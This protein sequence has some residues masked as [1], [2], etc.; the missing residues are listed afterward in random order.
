MDKTKV[1]VGS[2]ILNV[3]AILI[4]IVLVLI[5]ASAIGSI[6]KDY[7]NFFG[8]ATFAVK[9]NSME[10]NEDYNSSHP[11]YKKTS[12]KKGAFLFSKVLKTEEE[13]ASLQVGDVIIFR[14]TE[15]DVPIL[16]THRIVIV[17]PPM[18]E[19]GN[20]IRYTTKGDNNPISDSI[21]VSAEDVIGHYRGT[22]INGLGSVET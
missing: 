10:W 18:Q 5:V 8:S 6:G 9:T 11:E 15:Q 4:C 22:H 12:F 19:T 21:Q 1:K 3:I 17:H 16:V 14:T 13:R 2:V 20:I 7:V